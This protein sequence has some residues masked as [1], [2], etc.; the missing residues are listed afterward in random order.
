[1]SSFGPV[2]HGSAAALVGIVISSAVAADPQPAAPRVVDRLLAG[3]GQ[4]ERITCQVRRETVTP[5]GRSRFLST[6][7]WQRDRRMHVDNVEPLPR[8]I[9]ADGTHFFSFVHGD[10]K[11]FSRP[12]EKLSDEMSLGLRKVPGTA[13]EHL[14]LIGD[15]PETALPPEADLPV[16][17]GYA[18]PKVFAVLGLDASNR[19]ARVELFTGPDMS[20]RT[21]RYDYS[22]FTEVRP[23]AWIP[24]QQEATLSIGGADV[25]ETTRVDRLNT[26][27]PIAPN[28][29]NA[30]LYFP[31]VKFEDDFK[32]IYGP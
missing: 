4:I 9:V 1:M 17:V 6:I 31:G 28:L 30:S 5:Q 20:S 25:K 24:Q 8:T 3:Y 10:P 14:L 32:K 19:L 7:Y 22:R 12:I 13:M 23:G 15:A 27:D 26:T 18:T 2:V 11:G 29:F 16:R 21:A